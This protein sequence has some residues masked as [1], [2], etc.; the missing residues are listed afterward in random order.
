MFGSISSG[1]DPVKFLYKNAITFSIQMLFYKLGSDCSASFLRNQPRRTL[2]GVFCIQGR[3]QKLE[4]LLR[5]STEELKCKN[6]AIIFKFHV[7][8]DPGFILR[9]KGKWSRIYNSQRLMR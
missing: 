3:L 5:E 4:L 1:M 8:S 9:G 2:A 7:T 6:L